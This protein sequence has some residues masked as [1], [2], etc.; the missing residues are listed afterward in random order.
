MRVKWHLDRG[1][2][3]AFGYFPGI[4]LRPDPPRLLL[5]APALDFHPQTEAILRYLSPV[6][7]V[8]RIGL[9]VEWRKG[10]KVMFRIRGAE[11]PA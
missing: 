6:L 10:P 3:S 4:A 5:I 9:G 7:E 8:E 2:F 1:E 11:R